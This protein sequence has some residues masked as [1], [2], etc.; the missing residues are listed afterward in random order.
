[1]EPLHKM[2]QAQTAPTLRTKEDP[3]LAENCAW[4][5]DPLHNTGTTLHNARPPVTILV[6]NSF[7]YIFTPKVVDTTGVCIEAVSCAMG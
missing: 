4:H 5:I 2:P 7:V 1:M 3:S 6:V